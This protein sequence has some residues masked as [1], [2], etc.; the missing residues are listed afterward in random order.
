MPLKAY[1]TRFT[2]AEWVLL[3]F[4]HNRNEARTILT[5]VFAQEGEYIDT[6][7]VR[8]PEFDQYGAFDFAYDV[9]TNDDLPAGVVFYSDLWNREREE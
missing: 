3:V 1:R 8:V 4:A 6:R 7:A 9:Q 2:R 5:E